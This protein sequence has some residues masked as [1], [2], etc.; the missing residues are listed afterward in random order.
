M[1]NLDNNDLDKTKVLDNIN[2]LDKKIFDIEN[3]I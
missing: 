1:N 3:E 2:N